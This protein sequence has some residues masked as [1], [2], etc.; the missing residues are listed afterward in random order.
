MFSAKIFD[1]VNVPSLHKVAQKLQ[2]HCC[3][4]AA[5][6]L[7]NAMPYTDFAT[8]LLQI[9]CYMQLID[10]THFIGQISDKKIS[11]LSF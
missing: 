11:I 6:L 4:I 7:Q 3:N 2:Q 1:K 5:I 8:I 10:V 9:L